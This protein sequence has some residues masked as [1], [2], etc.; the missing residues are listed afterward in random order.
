MALLAEFFAKEP[1]PATRIEIAVA[2]L[3]ACYVNAHRRKGD[4]PHKVSDFLLFRDAWKQS[5]ESEEP[6]SLS[7][8]AMSFGK[9]NRGNHHR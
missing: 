9:V 1:D 5:E 3:T 4:Q 7:A 8:L 6:E 2:Q